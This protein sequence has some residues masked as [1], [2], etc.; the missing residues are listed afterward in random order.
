MVY[1]LKGD[2]SVLSQK[3]VSHS[4]SIKQS[5]TQFGQI[6]TQLNART[7]GGLLSDTIANP[8]NEAQVLE[9]VIRSGKVLKEPLRGE[10]SENMPKDKE[11]EV[12]PQRLKSNDEKELDESN[13]KV[14][15]VEKPQ[16]KEKTTIHVPPPFP[17]R[18]HKK[19]EN[20]KLRKFMKKLVEGNTI[21]ITY[22]CNAIMDSKFT[23]KKNDPGAFTIPCTIAAH[24]FAKALCDLG[25]SINLIPY[26]IYKKHGLYTTT[27][28]SMQLLMADRS[29]KRPIGVLFDVLVKVDKFILPVD[30]VELDCEMEQEVLII[31]GCPFFA[32][33]R[34]IVD[35]DMGE[36]KF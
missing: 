24:E 13:E 31:L 3:V 28:T 10:V 33:G 30:F 25:T 6:S 23:E 20:D 19:E 4:A 17:Q 34:G 9:I 29:I 15:E 14:V 12:T 5:E 8:K 2:F 7:I 21:E 22:G 36:I 18:L 16:R 1:V 27:S 11:N 26:V 32:T 35:L